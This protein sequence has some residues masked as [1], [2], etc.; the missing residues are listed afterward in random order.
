M[1]K[2]RHGIF[3]IG[4]ALMLLALASCGS[5]KDTDTEC[6]ASFKDLDTDYDGWI[7]KGEASVDKV[8]TSLF[9]KSDTSRDERLDENEYDHSPIVE[10]LCNPQDVLSNVRFGIE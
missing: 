10:K 3:I 5:Q 2:F 4:G 8:V 7:S 1:N 6:A 9:E